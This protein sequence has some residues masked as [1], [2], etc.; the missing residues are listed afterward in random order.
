MRKIITAIFVCVMATA[1]AQFNSEKSFYF[2]RSDNMMTAN[3]AVSAAW[4][5]TM[6]SSRWKVALWVKKESFSGQT[7]VIM[8]R[9]NSTVTAQ[10]QF[11]FF[12][13]SDTKLYF[14]LFGTNG[15]ND[16][17][18][19]ST[20]AMTTWPWS[21]FVVR[22][23]AT[24]PAT[25]RIQVTMNGSVVPG[26]ITQT[27][28]FSA[29]NNTTA[30]PVSIGGR[31]SSANYSSCKVSSVA[32]F[33]I[34][35]G[36]FDDAK[37]YSGRKSND[38][39]SID[40][41]GSCVSFMQCGT[42]CSFATQWVAQDLITLSGAWSSAGMDS[43]DYRSD[44][45]G[46][47]PC[48]AHVLIGQ[49]NAVGRADIDSLPQYYRG[50]I[51]WMPVWNGST[52]VPVNDSLNNNQY[53]EQAG[54]FGPEYSMADS[55]HRATGDTVWIFKVSKGA[56]TLHYRTNDYD[57]A[58]P[59]AIQPTG[60]EMYTRLRSELSALKAW[61]A[62]TNHTVTEVNIEWIQG[63]GDGE[64]STYACLYQQ[65]EVA[66]FQRNIHPYIFSLFG[67][68]PYQTDV[69]L[70]SAQVNIQ[71]R[72]TVNSAKQ[73]VASQYPRYQTLSTEGLSVMYE[74]GA[75]VHYGPQ[76]QIELGHRLANKYLTR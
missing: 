32:L 63:E 35:Y 51:Y 11:L 58:V 49:S 76:S 40:I 56:T 16:I 4:N 66:L 37:I 48:K 53:I 50:Y 57:W 68:W 43:S 6:A 30:A 18:W 62:S 75:Q 73:G 70:S 45:P 33:N 19:K 52:F 1:Y 14:R 74:S 72:T 9:D 31:S 55:I 13:S 23:D 26:S 21:L 67:V 69:L 71:Y 65:N 29:I 41:P 17:S 15:T 54:G 12:V 46:I 60:G 25:A 36:D 20:S 2:D 8:C 38:I 10:R 44:Y 3:T 22:Y 28:T 42:S 39:R 34:A 61:E 59:N 24:L 5:T 7:E 64:D 47:N 27:G